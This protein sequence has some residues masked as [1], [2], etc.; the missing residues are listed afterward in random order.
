MGFSSGFQVNIR[1]D[2]AT[3][4]LWIN[5]SQGGRMLA[6]AFCLGFRVVRFLCSKY[7]IWSRV[8]AENHSR[9][10][11]AYSTFSAASIRY[12]SDWIFFSPTLE[13]FFNYFLQD[14]FYPDVEF[15]GWKNN[16]KNIYLTD[17]IASKDSCRRAT[18]SYNIHAKIS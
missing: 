10:F 18:L 6:T 11:M 15:Y 13:E 1:I 16:M 17:K 12:F 5:K 9:N 8:T 2:I 14:R 3:R 4:S 7:G